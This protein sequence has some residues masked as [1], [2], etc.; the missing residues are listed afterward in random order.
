[1]AGYAPAH[2]A[3]LNGPESF[4][5]NL[6]GIPAFLID[7]QGSGR[8]VHTKWFWVGPL[9]LF[10][11]VSIVAGIVLTPIAQHVMETAPIPDGVDPA[12]Y[13]QRLQQGFKFQSYAI[14]LAPITTA[15]I[16]ALQAVILFGMSQIFTV[17]ATF[18]QMFNLIAGCSI[19]QL[20]SSI[21]SV[22]IL[23]TKGDIST[24]AELRPALGLDIFL[25]EGTNKFLMAFLGYFSIFEIWWMVML[26]LVVSAAFKVNKSKAVMIVAPLVLISLLFRIGGAVFQ[27]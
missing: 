23:K 5:D 6:A 8:R 20:L 18:R 22:I 24:M 17:R 3:P 1:M 26:V 9:V 15:I 2:E 13:Q 12:V 14:Y 27:R 11:I 7:P 25:P 16:F 21:A 19:I 4:A 10:S